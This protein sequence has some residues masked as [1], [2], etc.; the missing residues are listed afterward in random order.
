MWQA[1]VLKMLGRVVRKG[2]LTAIMPDGSRHVFGEG[3][4]PVVTVRLSDAEHLRGLVRD[5]ELALGESYMDGSLT[6]EE[7][8]LRQLLTLFAVNGGRGVMP[9][10]IAAGYRARFLARRWVQA[11]D[12]RKARR[13]VAHHYD[14]G[15]AFYDLFLDEDRQYS[16]AYFPDPD[17]TLEE[18]Q[19]AKKAHIARKLCI[20]PGMRV[21]D[22]GCG[23]G[24][25]ALTLARDFDARVTGVTLS[26]N[27]HRK[28]T[29]RAREAGLS[30]RIEI[31]LQDYRDLT[32]PFD[33]IVSV[34][35]LEH[36]GQPQYVTYF[37][38]VADLLS[39]DGVALI[40][41]IGRCAPPSTTSSWLAKYIFPGGYTPSLSEL[42][43]P[44]E[45]TDLWQADIEVW[46]GH[47]AET[48]RRW[49]ERFEAN[50]DE[51]RAMYD[52]RF[53]R[54][55]R[56]Y[57]VAA[58]VGFDANRHVVYQMQLSKRRE[59]VPNSRDY[60]YSKT[61]EAAPAAEPATGVAA[62]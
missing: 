24:G 4:D 16:C 20:E 27:Q 61:P 33:R 30:D 60:L 47:Y 51:V 54:M 59:T 36:V 2:R 46:R 52:D 35:M 37:D 49:Q 32:G 38:K 9:P 39:D 55:W 42:L 45:R 25:M 19:A 26:E 62:Q 43:T 3:G 58:E 18:A 15:D 31:R 5:P 11:N 44:I 40:H 22:I 12:P 23:W 17:M 10:M 7:G 28:A 1:I 14:L 13:N 8:D 48:L 50:V 53:I 41:T 6:I 57:L 21:L 34:G 29:Q 56:Y